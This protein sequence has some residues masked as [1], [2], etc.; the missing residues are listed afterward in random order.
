MISSVIKGELSTMIRN[1]IES[2]TT[3]H[4]LEQNIDR[5]GFRVCFNVPAADYCSRSLIIILK[6]S[7]HILAF[8]KFIQNVYDLPNPALKYFS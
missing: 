8:L 3:L 4:Y 6:I 5:Y 1:N 2:F 7:I